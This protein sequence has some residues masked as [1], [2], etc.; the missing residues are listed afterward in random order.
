MARPIEATPSLSGD[1]AETLAASLE[2]VASADQIEQ[3]RKAAQ[4]FFNAVTRSRI[5][6]P[7]REKDAD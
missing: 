4:A 2:D 7:R 1:E 6:G 5:S 3:R